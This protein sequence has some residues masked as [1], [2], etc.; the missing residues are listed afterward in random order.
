MTL[1][2]QSNY[3]RNTSQNMTQ[4]ILF[5]NSHTKPKISQNLL[6]KYTNIAVNPQIHSGWPHI[7]NTRI[8][9]VDIFRAI[10]KG[11]TY[12]RITMDFK[13]MGVRVTKIELEDAFNFTLSWLN[14]ASNEREKKASK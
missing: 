13:E 10:V 6:Q 14:E 1:T 4:E 12:E 2:F 5:P 3:D 9:A 7:Q 8:L 11:Y